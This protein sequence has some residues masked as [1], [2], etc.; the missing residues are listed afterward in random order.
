[1]AIP[2]N[3]FN[4][5]EDC[6]LFTKVNRG[7]MVSVDTRRWRIRP[8]L[9]L[10]YNLNSAEYSARYHNT[11]IV[12]YL[13]DGTVVLDNGGYA[14]ISTKRHLNGC[15]PFYVFQKKMVWWACIGD[16]VVRFGDGLIVEPTC[17]GFA[18]YD[19]RRDY[20]YAAGF[21]CGRVFDSPP[22]W[23]VKLIA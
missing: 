6:H 22:A 12:Q 14:T 3:A 8:N 20:L 16:S 2:Y 15:G 19:R 18:V 4:S 21:G 23:F 5:Y 9:Y 11:D 10:R 1:M 13:P 17:D 7:Q